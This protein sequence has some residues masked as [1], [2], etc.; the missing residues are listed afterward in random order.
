MTREELYDVLYDYTTL[1]RQSGA[2]T[3]EQA[4]DVLIQL[5]DIVDNNNE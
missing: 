2:L 4:D 5:T 3:T 1:L